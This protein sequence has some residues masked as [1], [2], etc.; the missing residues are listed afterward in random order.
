M[1][2]NLIYNLYDINPNLAHAIKQAI[3]S[4]IEH[5]KKLGKKIDMDEIYANI[6]HDFLIIKGDIKNLEIY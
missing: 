5:R 4:E 2:T 1:E 6:D 3:K